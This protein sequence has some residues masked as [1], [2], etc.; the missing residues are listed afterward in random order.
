MMYLRDI[1]LTVLTLAV[2]V[3]GV[4]AGSVAPPS[5]QEQALG[6]LTRRTLVVYARDYLTP[7]FADYVPTP[8][9]AA[10]SFAVSMARGEFEPVQVGLFV[11]ALGGQDI[12]NVQIKVEHD[13]PFETG[14]VFYD[15]SGLKLRPIDVGK[16]YA[17]Y[18][19]G[20]RP[21]PLYVVPGDTIR[22]IKRGASAAFWITFKTDADTGPGQYTGR[23]TVTA[24]RGSTQTFGIQVEVRPLTLPRPRTVFSMYYRPDRIPGHWSRK[25]QQL[26]ARDMAAHGMN[27]AQVVSFFSAFGKDEYLRSGRLPL[28]QVSNSFIEPWTGLLEP[29]QYADG[30]VDPALL[31]GEQIEIFKKAGLVHLDVPIFTVQDNVQC[32]HKREIAD[33]LRRLSVENEWPQIVLQTRDEPPHALYGP[34][35]LSA[36]TLA[37]MLEFKRLANCRTFTA[38]SGHAAFAWGHLH[39]VWVVLGGHIT[40]QM[41]REAQRQGAEVWTYLHDLRITNPLVNRHY[42]GL[43]TWALRLAGNAPYAYASY[44][45]EPPPYQASTD[46]VW[47]PYDGKP[48]LAQVMGFVLP[49]PDGPIPGVGHEGRR[50]GIDDYRYLQLLEARLEAADA[51]SPVVPEARQWLAS[52][53][54]RVL[55]DVSEGIYY[56]RF[57]GLWGLDWYDPSPRLA[58]DQ[59]DHVRQ[60]ATRFIEQLPPAP[61]EDNAPAPHAERTFPASGWEGAAF[62]DKSLS[63]CAAAIRRGDTATKRAAACSISVRRFELLEAAE[64]SACIDALMAFLNDPDVRVPAMRALRP[65]GAQAAAALPAV[66][67]LLRAED[68]YIRCG[69]ILVCEAIGTAAVDGLIDALKDPVP[70]NAELAAG[71]LARLGP[72]ATK[73]QDAVEALLSSTSP[74]VRSHAR[75]ALNQIR[76]S[77]PGDPAHAQ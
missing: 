18:P 53:R 9:E 36:E 50:E 31:V 48:S 13:L 22:R 51:G 59:Y 71:C 64:S 52:L 60:I 49:S 42:A 46:P 34:H 26:Y 63:Q 55:Y 19:G 12:A 54:Q 23:F 30:S 61:G 35:A 1:A 47:L 14:Y 39:D 45:F 40:P 3:T 56:G 43:Y 76:H 17:T 28:S 74:T 8:A 65:F 38:L 21:M 7:C 27:S 75:Y 20:R 62:D 68:A 44:M 37:S 25:Y 16:P 33:T 15:E 77:A 57:D 5:N 70:A 73:A 32:E 41:V 29:D 69:A 67:E 2:V 58:A 6:D 10:A 24:D 66:H 11:P 4:R 72:L